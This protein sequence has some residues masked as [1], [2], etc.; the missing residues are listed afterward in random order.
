MEDAQ[1]TELF[2]GENR[3]TVQ[4]NSRRKV[5]ET[6]SPRTSLPFPQIG[7]VPPTPKDLRAAF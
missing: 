5:A 7:K 3:K 4:A 1:I 6:Q 2:D